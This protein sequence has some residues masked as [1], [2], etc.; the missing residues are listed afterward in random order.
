LIGSATK[1]PALSWFCI[2]AGLGVIFC[3]SADS[4]HTCHGWVG[5]LELR[6]HLGV[7]LFSPSL[8]QLHV[9]SSPFFHVR[10]AYFCG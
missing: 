5:A 10:H 6:L 3:T 9:W 1:L 2:F 8:L 7:L 4:V